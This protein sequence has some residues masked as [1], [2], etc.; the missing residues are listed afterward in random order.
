MKLCT[1]LATVLAE[2]MLTPYYSEDKNPTGVQPSLPPGLSDNTVTARCT[3]DT[4]A[5]F[6][7]DLPYRHHIPFIRCLVTYVRTPRANSNPARCANLCTVFGR[8]QTRR[9]L[10]ACST[11]FVLATRDIHNPRPQFDTSWKLLCHHHASA[12][13]DWIYSRL[14]ANEKDTISFTCH[15]AVKR[16]LPALPAAVFAANASSIVVYFPCDL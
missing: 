2:A 9:V 12:A 10:P 8:R 11:S 1:H 16:V 6:L 14:A 4:L 15:L 13:H 3:T 7:I 5:R